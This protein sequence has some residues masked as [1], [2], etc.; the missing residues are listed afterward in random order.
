MMK[1]Q[2]D[3]AGRLFP[4]VLRYTVNVL[5]DLDRFLKHIGIDSLYDI[6]TLRA[7]CTARVHSIGSVHIPDLDLFKS[8]KLPRNAER[9]ADLTQFLFHFGCFL[10]P[11]SQIASAVYADARFIIIARQKGEVN[12]FLRALPPQSVKNVNCCVGTCAI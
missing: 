3:A 6:R 5:H 12:R 11:R 4:D 7:V 1:V 10:L 8:E 2:R 9:I